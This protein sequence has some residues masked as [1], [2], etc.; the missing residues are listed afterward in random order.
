[1]DQGTT[2]IYSSRAQR[3]FIEAFRLQEDFE[4]L[5]P[6]AGSNG[7]ALEHNVTKGPF[8]CSPNPRI[9]PHGGRRACPEGAVWVLRAPG[10]AKE[11]CLRH[12]RFLRPRSKT[13][14]CEIRLAPT[15]I[16][17]T[18]RLT[19]ALL[20]PSVKVTPGA[21]SQRGSRKGREK[22]ASGPRV[23]PSHLWGHPILSLF[24][25]PPVGFLCLYLN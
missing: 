23:S 13:D 25:V 20:P 7:A 2:K 22:R 8:L 24:Y 12:P 3:A 18:K 17:F 4:P 1:M 11:A 6:C 15:K 14:F 5:L 21:D 16:A 10:A 19:S 9:D